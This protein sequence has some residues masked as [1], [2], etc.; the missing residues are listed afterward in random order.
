MEFK[1]YNL[2]QL[3]AYIES[4]EFLE[5]EVIAITPLRVLSQ[6][7]NPN[8]QA[9]DIVLST[10][11]NNE[12]QIIGF[13]GALPDKVNGIKCAWNSCWWVK[14]GT[15]AQVSMKLL[16]TFIS[17]WQKKVLFSEMTPHTS[18][19]IE[20]LGF[21]NT[22]TIAGFR[23]YY[24]FSLAEVLPGKKK[25][26]EKIKKIL[27]ITDFLLNLVLR[28]RHSFQSIKPS[29][30]TETTQTLT[31]NDDAF[32]SKFNQN[33]P[34]KRLSIEFN[35]IV[36]NPWVTLSSPATKKISKRYYFTY[37]AKRFETV[38]VRFFR[39]N[40]MLALV[41]YT[42]RN[43]AL[44][45]CYVFC[46]SS[47]AESISNYFMNLLKTDRKIATITTFHE[48]LSEVFNKQP[49]GFLYKVRLPKYSAISNELLNE[50]GIEHP[51]FQMGDG[52]AIFT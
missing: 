1:N 18:Q 13:I 14:P 32:I 48:S 11:C 35:W 43:E 8:A 2:A 50:S 51:E 28:F 16:F 12:G 29:L 45:L 19:I 40:E 9:N 22:K 47:D 23:G 34:S 36:Q 24:R 31:P 10:A 42:I 21:C 26:L 30:K 49:K 17:N 4:G 39:D 52:D 20:K 44:K 6:L 7:K 27:Q 38:W 15:P 37:E 33:S 41:N 46:H 25:T 3:K 5:S